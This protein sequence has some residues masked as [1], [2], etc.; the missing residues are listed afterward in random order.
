MP[1]FSSLTAVVTAVTVA[2]LGSLA[3]AQDV[4]LSEVHPEAGWIELHNTGTTT[5][6]LTNW[7]IYL[8]TDTPGRPNN[9]WWGFAGG[10]TIAPDDFLR[11][12][13]MAPRQPATQHEV[14]TGDTT[15]WFL[16]GLGAESLPATRGAL[17][18]I[19]TRNS[20]LVSSPVVF[21]DWV[22]WGSGGLAREDVAEQAGLWVQGH[23]APAIPVQCSLAYDRR[24]Q[25]GANPELA[26]FVD[27]T[28][29][30]LQPNTTLA[31]VET[32]GQPCTPIGHHLLGP[33]ALATTSAP[34]IGNGNFALEITNTTGLF[35]ETCVIGFSM[36]Q[37]PASALSLL[38]TLSGG[39]ACRQWIDPAAAFA[40]VWLSS[41]PGRT[42]MPMSLQSLSPALV[43]LRFYAQ[44]MVFDPW[45]TSWPPYQGVTNGLSIALGQ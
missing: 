1:S 29:T 39:A 27:P 9:Y 10:T 35:M 16:F 24:V 14:Y 6:D 3:V 25:T 34:I 15:F 28:P 20:Q 4:I 11:V 31:S 32:V 5:A 26:W 2:H 12:H 37:S 19:S 41:H 17:A 22:S 18:L 33:P 38:P 42:S 13:W 30:P 8:A 36:Q 23:A 44:A 45:T 40:T 21:R 7:S 43:G